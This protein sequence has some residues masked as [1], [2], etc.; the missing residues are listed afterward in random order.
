MVALNNPRISLE[1]VDWLRANYKPRCIGPKED[2]RQADRYAGAVELA[3]KLIRIAT[4][5]PNNDI[6]EDIG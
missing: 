6:E 2:L 1:L 3:Q 5:D 4:G